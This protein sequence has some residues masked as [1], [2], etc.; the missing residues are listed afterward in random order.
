MSGIIKSISIEN[1]RG[2]KDKQ[3]I[4]LADP[5]SFTVLIG[6]NNTG[7][8][9]LPR[10]LS[11]LIDKEIKGD[12][13]S[14]S[15]KD[16]HLL[17][18]EKIISISMVLDITTLSDEI[19]KE[20]QQ[21]NISEVSL[22]YQIVRNKS[23]LWRRFYTIH[24]I[25]THNYTM[26]DDTL[27]VTYNQEQIENLTGKSLT[28][29]IDDWTE[30]LNRYV[31]DKILLFHAVR[32]IDITIKD[33]NFKTGKDLLN[34]LISDLDQ[35]RK[36]SIIKQTREYLARL[37]LDVP[38]NITVRSNKL[39]FLF[40]D[41]IELTSDEIGTGYTMICVL[42]ME[43]LRSERKII[44][45]DELES[46][47]QPGLIR[48]L[49]DILREVATDTQFI[50]PTHSPTILGATT[51]KDTIHRF[52]KNKN[53]NACEV[54][55]F[56]RQDSPDTIRGICDDLGVIPGDALLSNCILWVEGPSEIYWLRAWIKTYL[57]LKHPKLYLIEGLHYSILM[58]GGGLI[59]PMDFTED[60]YDLEEMEL[61]AKL[62]VLRVNP[63]AVVIIDS[64]NA[65]KGGEKENRSLRIA[66]QLHQQNKNLE[67]VRYND[68]EAEITAIEQ[69]EQLPNMWRFAAK[70]LENY[71][72]PELLKAF[73]TKLAKNNRSKVKCSTKKKINWDVYS[74]DKGVG[75]LLSEQG[76]EGVKANGSASGAIK[77]KIALA[78]YVHQHFDTIHLEQS[79]S[80]IA[81]PNEEMITEITT[82]LEKIISY[83]KDVNRMTN[84]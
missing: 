40:P 63:H 24:G 73:Y 81:K 28:F 21:S 55:S 39:T 82:R 36:R 43:I 38:Q 7:K 5:G 52:V 75:L 47:L 17:E 2:F 45:V 9:L 26:R 11:L 67:Y 50:F 1:Y 57:K 41:N 68:K 32:S 18:I 13:S 65:S 4:K 35:G 62:R 3:T 29:G 20:L 61:K 27:D 31:L 6:Q 53:T 69:I 79:P 42:L 19:Q 71:C 59:A 16:F 23:I 10:L 12:N 25:P 22:E 14:L 77:H 37:S 78:Q 30:K 49:L 48:V 58:S 66:Q 8:S 15:D 74:P 80:G 34:W 64:D 51:E 60:S 56:R 46:H 83:I 70:E 33:E 44:V 72:H 76:V 54:Q 84:L